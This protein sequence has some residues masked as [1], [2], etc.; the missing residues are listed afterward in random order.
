M[1]SLSPADDAETPTPLWWD[2][3]PPAAPRH[4]ASPRPGL[5]AAGA[6]VGVVWSGTAIGLGLCCGERRHCSR[7]ALAIKGWD[8]HAANDSS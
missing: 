3:E 4:C 2:Q 1:Q 7:L 6:G 5:G 8:L